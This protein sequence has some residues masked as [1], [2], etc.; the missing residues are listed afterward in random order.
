MKKIVFFIMLSLSMKIYADKEPPLVK[1]TKEEL[2]WSKKFLK[3]ERHQQKHLYDYVRLLKARYILTR[4]M[5]WVS[6]KIAEAISVQS[7][8]MLIQE[9]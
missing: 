5:V 6:T 7:S 8:M 2:K 3:L 9:K 1:V 4:E